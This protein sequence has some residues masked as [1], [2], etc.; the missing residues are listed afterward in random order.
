[1]EIKKSLISSNKY[2]LKCPYLLDY[3]YV[4]FHNTDNS[5]SAK[6]EIAYMIGND[7][8]T[9]FHIA[10]DDIEAI[11]GIPL[12][13]N[14]WAC[15]DGQGKGN[16]ES[17][18]VEICYNALGADNPKFKKSEDNAVKV[19]AKLLRDKGLGI[20][21]LKPHKYWSGKNCPSTTNHAEFIARVKKELE[22][23]NDGWNKEN[24]KWY[25]YKNGNKYAGWIQFKDK[26]YYCMPNS[27]EMK[28][29]WLEYNHKWYYFM[30]P[31]GFMKTGWLK[32]NNTWYYFETDGHMLSNCIWEISGKKYKF[33]G[34]G[35]LKE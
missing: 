13:R 29:G 35:R 30:H 31:S 22:N 18:S 8:V 24:S 11:M 16:R 15:G 21:R 27:F 12:N 33:E 32:Y 14:A 9:G 26:W 20:D 23:I 3:Q 25:Y 17:V 19:C 1:M 2:S 4:T 7:S 6:N 34:D 28:I 10:V 5:A